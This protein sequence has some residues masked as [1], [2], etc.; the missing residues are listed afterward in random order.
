ML[1][2]VVDLSAIPWYIFTSYYE[3]R[4]IDMTAAM[5]L[6]FDFLNSK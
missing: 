6:R 4:G 5:K 2:R 1:A 3:K